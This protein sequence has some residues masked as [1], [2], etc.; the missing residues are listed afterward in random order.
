MKALI[1]FVLG[2]IVG[3]YGLRLYEQRSAVPPV[4]TNPSIGDTT[5]ESA[6]GVGDAV[7]E[8]LAAWHLT[9]DDIRADLAQ[10]GEV[11]RTKAQGMGDQIADARIVTV[12][13]AK[14]VLD[15]NLSARDL[16]VQ[17][18]DGQV[19]L[20]G[21]VPQSDL[22]GRAVMLALDTDG[23]RNVASHIAVQPQAP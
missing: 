10:T 6:A 18:H 22:I 13:K 17:S 9:P 14:Y 4:T 2:A 19:T 8:K 16:D 23:V 20:T 12:I 21:T 3:A 7:S 1:I 15:H 11:V 5:R